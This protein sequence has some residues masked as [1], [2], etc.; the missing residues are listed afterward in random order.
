MSG[1]RERQPSTQPEGRGSIG[2]YR[3]AEGR[4]PIKGRGPVSG[5]GPTGRRGPMRNYGPM[6]IGR[7]VRKAKDFKGTL[8]RLLKYL[9]PHRARLAV[10]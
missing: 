9:K 10:C 2:D 3:S 4:G 7:T 5:P 6:G 1:Q 8:K